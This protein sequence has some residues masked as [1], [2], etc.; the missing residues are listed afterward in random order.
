ML[1]NLNHGLISTGTNLSDC[2][3]Q[4]TVGGCHTRAS[5]KRQVAVGK[6]LAIGNASLQEPSR[7]HRWS[8]PERPMTSRYRSRFMPRHAG[9]V[10]HTMD[11][12]PVIWGAI[13]LNRTILT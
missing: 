6:H 5:V 4:L 3:R 2:V 11:L 12:P 7:P 8:S 10:A 13:V 9:S 1:A